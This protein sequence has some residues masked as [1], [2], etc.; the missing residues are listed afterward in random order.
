MQ[1]G[2]P[3]HAGDPPG[4]GRTLADGVDGFLVADDREMSEAVVLLAR[5][6]G[7]LTDMRRH[8]AAVLPRF[9]WSDVL[10]AVEAEYLRATG[11]VSASP[12]GSDH[13]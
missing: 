4:S 9:D 5:D 7:V 2:K 6:S 3:G 11:L 12:A 8:N 10:A 1:S 13:D